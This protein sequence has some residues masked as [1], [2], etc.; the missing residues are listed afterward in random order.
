MP[1]TPWA[2]KVSTPFTEASVL[3]SPSM[4]VT[5]A[6]YFSLAY[7]DEVLHVG[8]VVVGLHGD[9]DLAD[10]KGLLP[11]VSLSAGE[12]V[13]QEEQSE[14]EDHRKSQSSFHAITPFRSYM[15][16]FLRTAGP[17]SVAHPRRMSSF[18]CSCL[19]FLSILLFFHPFAAFFP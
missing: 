1:F 5:S 10:L 11:R 8:L 7:G 17:A 6:L 19:P 3:N 18:I 15:E 14:D 16:S 2:M 9:R 12:G 4:T 13:G